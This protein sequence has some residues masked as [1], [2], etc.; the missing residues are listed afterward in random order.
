MGVVGIIITD[1]HDDWATPKEL[2]DK[3]DE[4]FNFDFDPCPLNSNFNGLNMEWGQSNYVNPPYNR[5]DKPKF[6]QKAYD[7]WSK[8]KKV[9]MLLPVSTSTKQFH[10]I[11]LPNAEIRFIRGRI[12]FIENGKQTKQTGTRD[13]MLVIFK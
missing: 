12:K 6:I 1:S 11:I 10:E 13:L 4:E 9:V 2:Y 5:F 3:W 7:E 8:G